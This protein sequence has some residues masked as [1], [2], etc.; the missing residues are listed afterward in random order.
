M[1]DQTLVDANDTALVTRASGGVG[2]VLV[3]LASYIEW[4]ETRPLLSTR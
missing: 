1:L 2:S 4:N 3:Q